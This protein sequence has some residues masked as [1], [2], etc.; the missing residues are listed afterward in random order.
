METFSIRIIWSDDD[1]GYIATSP[2]FEDLSA[3]GATPQEAA[4]QLESVVRVAIATYRD[5][6]WPL[7][8]PKRVHEHSGQL[9]LRLPKSLHGR[10]VEEADR[11]GVSLNTLIVTYLAQQVGRAASAVSASDPRR[12]V[13]HLRA[14]PVEE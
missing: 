9:R 12:P 1:G 11:D 8:E 2:E 14:M 10:L 6:G 13:K 7:P 3:F 4:A 5:S